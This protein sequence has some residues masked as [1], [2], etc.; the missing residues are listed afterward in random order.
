MSKAPRDPRV[1]AL[2]RFAISISALNVLGYTVLGFEQPWL[3]PIVA[4]LTAY[5]TE[6]VLEVVGARAERRAPRFRGGGVRGAVEFFYPAHITALAVNMLLYPND[7]ILVMVF[8]VVT[9]VSSKWML[10][11]PAR[12]RLVHFMNPSNFGITVVL[13][14]FP[15]VSISPPYQFTEHVDTLV[16]WLLPAAILV[17]GTMLNAKLTRRTWLIAGWLSVF[18]AQAVFR[19]LVLDVSIPNALSIMTG[20]AFI[21]FTN[22]MI[23]DPGTTPFRPA[24]QFAFGGGVA[25]V[26]GLLTGVSVVYG[27]FF[28]TAIV[29]LV[30]GGFLWAVHAV[31]RQRATAEAPA[32]ALGAGAAPANGRAPAP[33]P[34]PAAPATVRA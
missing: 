5:A 9:A 12:G 24:S 32:P 34:E 1:T 19:G 13:L 33:V 18:V 28:A 29:C 2:R 14:L 25:L 6:A 16:D 10:R 23:T 21:L 17:L 15:W 3:W 26:Y 11:A 7:R 27:L 31:E 30:R 22:Y 20:V 8:G 4:V